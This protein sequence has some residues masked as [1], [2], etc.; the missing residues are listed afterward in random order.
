[1]RTTGYIKLPRSIQA[2]SW[3]RKPACRLVALHLL[4]E[5]SYR[6]EADEELGIVE[7]GSYR[8]SVRQLATEIG[9]SVQSVRT[10]LDTHKASGFVEVEAIANGG[11]ADGLSMV[12]R[13]ENYTSLRD[14]NIMLNN[15][16]TNTRGNTRSTFVTDET[17]INYND[18]KFLL[19][20]GL[21]HGLTHNNK[22][23]INNTHTEYNYPGRI[24]KA[25]A[26]ETH[27]YTREVREL[28]QWMAQYTPDFLAMEIPLTPQRMAEMIATYPM[29][30]IQRLLATAWSKGACSRHRS[31][32]QAFKSFARNDR[33]LKAPTGEK[34]YT[35]AEVCD[36]VTRF[37]IRQEEA[38]EMVPARAG[39]KPKWRRIA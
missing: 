21:T 18:E 28:E 3:Y 23:N 19:T 39:E 10:A 6:D 5:A 35:Y 22:E 27:A 32:W 20:H 16:R 12:I 25:R 30:D 11:R 29:A 24:L 13:W 17:T 1:M 7:V 15:T 37:N 31:A 14:S 4:L 8:T 2:A 9:I 38:F 33:E 26:R 34:L 36:Y